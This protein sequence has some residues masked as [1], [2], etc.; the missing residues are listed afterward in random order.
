MRAMGPNVWQG[1]TVMR[2]IG[3]TVTLSR[4][5]AISGVGAPVAFYNI[6]FNTGVD[7]YRTLSRTKSDGYRPPTLNDVDVWAQMS[8]AEKSQ[9]Q[10]G[11]VLSLAGDHIT[12]EKITG[13]FISVLFNGCN[14]STMRDCDFKGGWTWGCCAFL[15]FTPNRTCYNAALNNRFREH[16]FEGIL[17]MGCDGWTADGNVCFA[18]GDSG[19]E[20]YQS[21][22]GSGHQRPLFRRLHRRKIEQQYAN[23]KLSRRD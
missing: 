16:G 2:I 17:F 3:T 6:T 20:T 4:P 11:P 7:A 15:N 13:R 5:N 10:I 9:A 18:N 1:A 12:V 21:R 23:R 19:I 14:W 22:S 8:E